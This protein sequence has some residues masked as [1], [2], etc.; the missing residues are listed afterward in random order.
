MR[1]SSIIILA[2]LAGYKILRALEFWLKLGNF[3]EICKISISFHR[4]SANYFYLLNGLEKL[5]RESENKKL[6]NG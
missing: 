3:R 1:L 6:G 2:I 4:E 5:S